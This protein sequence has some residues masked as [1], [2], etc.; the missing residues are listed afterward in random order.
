MRQQNRKGTI[1]LVHR[2]H[3]TGIAA[4]DYQ[5]GMA[6]QVGGMAPP[7]MN[8]KH[9]F[10]PENENGLLKVTCTGIALQVCHAQE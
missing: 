2:E 6:R 1:F 3:L 9:S 8:A 4:Q 10:A 7:P 5:R